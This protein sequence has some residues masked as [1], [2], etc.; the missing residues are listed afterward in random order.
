MIMGITPAVILCASA[1][2][3]VHCP[4]GVAEGPRHCREP[5][6]CS[7]RCRPGVV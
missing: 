1:S 7:A 4:S 6:P 5:R 3:C 2:L